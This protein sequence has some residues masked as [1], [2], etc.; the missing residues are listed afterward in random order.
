MAH[1]AHFD[2]TK[3]W[4]KNFFFKKFSKLC[5]C[6]VWVH[7]L[8][9]SERAQKLQHMVYNIFR[10]HQNPSSRTK[11]M[12]NQKL[13]PIGCIWCI[14]SLLWGFHYVGILAQNRIG[15]VLALEHITDKLGVYQ[16]YGQYSA[17][18]LV[19]STRFHIF[20][21]P[22]PYVHPPGTP[23]ASWSPKSPKNAFFFQARACCVQAL[24]K[25]PKRP[26]WTPW[27][28]SFPTHQLRPP[29]DLSIQKYSDFALFEKRDP[30]G[31]K[32]D[33]IL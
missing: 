31:N 20:R 21:A 4:K 14:F 17:W 27:V 33:L 22:T 12:K 7:I 24:E 13:G 29:S 1:L 25:H 8:G 28:L 18:K 11:V 2:F 3:F 15:V 23:N 16:W 19:T 6:A 30:L 9:V 26:K 32:T 5:V 10:S